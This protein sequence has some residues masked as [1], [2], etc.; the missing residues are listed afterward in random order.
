LGEVHFGTWR[1]YLDAAQIKDR[2]SIMIFSL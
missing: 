1:M 2:I